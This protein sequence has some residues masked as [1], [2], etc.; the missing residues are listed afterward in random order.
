VPAQLL[1]VLERQINFKVPAEAPTSG[2]AA[3][4]CDG[5]WREQPAGDG[6]VRQAEND[7]L[8]RGPAYVHMPVWIEVDRARP[9]DISTRTRSDPRSFGG[10]RFEVRRDGVMLKPFEIRGAMDRWR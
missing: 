10:D 4:R 1:A 7:G 3:D 6:A 9:Y 5:A 8:G 2:E